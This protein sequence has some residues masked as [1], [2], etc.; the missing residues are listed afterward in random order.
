VAPGGPFFGADGRRGLQ[1]VH[2]GHHVVQQDQGERLARL[3]RLLQ[4]RQCLFS[5]GDQSRF[6][7][8]M[9]EHALQDTAVGGIVIDGQDRQS[10]QT[11]ALRRQPPLRRF[12]RKAE[13]GREMERAPASRLALHPEPSPH[14]LHQLRRDGQPQAGPAVLARGRG[15]ELRE[16]FE[17]FLHV[18]GR[19]IDARVDDGEMQVD[20][21]AGLRLP[22][23]PN[24]D[25]AV[26][27]ELDR[28]A[29]QIDHDLPRMS[30]TTASR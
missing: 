6:H 16:G 12:G 8:P 17:Q 7:A 29:R 14:H 30:L 5:T 15:V 21:I 9:R 2:L 28:V 13:A 22:L 24:H 10:A 27:G 18:V 20:P 26:V 19:D 23:D 25:L 4:H 3:L 11:R 1:P